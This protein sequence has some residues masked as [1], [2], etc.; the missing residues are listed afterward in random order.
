VEGERR[1][2]RAS[3]ET[4]PTSR[5]TNRNPD[6]QFTNNGDTLVSTNT[7]V[8]QSVTDQTAS[9]LLGGNGRLSRFTFA[10]RESAESKYNFVARN[11]TFLEGVL[12]D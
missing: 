2:K 11:S 6:V 7:R 8:W 9:V 5:V 10:L 4:R 1:D 3:E 12:R